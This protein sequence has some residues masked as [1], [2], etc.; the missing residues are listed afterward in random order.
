MNHNE[1]MPDFSGG[2]LPPL[3]LSASCRHTL[4]LMGPK[5]RADTESRRYY[6]WNACYVFSA[7]ERM[8]KNKQW[9]QIK[10]GKKTEGAERTEAE[11]ELEGGG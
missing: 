7:N 3:P 9:G 8:K 5:A 1:A 11:K 4:T 2:V 10:R 6:S